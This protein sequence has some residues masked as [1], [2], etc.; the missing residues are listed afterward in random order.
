M[1]K[2]PITYALR[3]M[4]TFFPPQKPLVL[5][6]AG[7]TKKLA[8][9]MIKNGSKRPLIVTDSFLLQNGMLDDLLQFLRNEGSE[10]TIFDGIIPNPTF[11]VV[12]A[13]I[14]LAQANNCDSVFTVGGGSA[15]DTAKVIAA[16][17]TNG[18]R[19]DKLVGILK[20]KK[21]P[22]PFY[23][24]PTTS[25]TGS[26]V[27]TA[28]VISNTETHAKEFFVDPKYIPIATA[29]DPLMLKTL[30]AAMTAATGMDALTHAI[31]AYTSLNNFTD[32][33]RDASLAIKL[34]FDYLPIAFE[35]GENLNAREMVSIASFL[36]G[37]AFTKSSLGY[38]HAISHQVSAHYG[39]PH[40]LANAVILP[41]V[42]RYNKTACA[43][44]YADLER[45]LSSDNIAGLD[46]QELTARF[47]ARVDAL[48]D[49]LNIPASIKD[50][51]EKDYDAIAKSAIKEA[52]SSYAVPKS[53]NRQAINSV[54]A[55]VASG[56]RDVS[57][58]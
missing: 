35:D 1:F 29:L 55:A 15:I 3:F 23:V 31:E 46:D 32:T 12:E 56:N 52:R 24:A 51:D 7:T 57:F 36:A 13:G 14:D 39:T 10:V 27:T 6:G 33:D 16:A 38:V 26:E 19:T 8:E 45:M 47:I 44:R 37:F 54:L 25:G 53:M 17:M 58:G 30:P 41:R 18:N 11:A 9:L 20:V 48:G 42:L 43:K 49:K 40:G 21:A 2:S 34:L 5:T 22:L 28:A 4:S 50:L